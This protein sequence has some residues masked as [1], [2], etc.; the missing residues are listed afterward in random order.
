MR[1]G[2]RN[3]FAGVNFQIE[4]ERA[5]QNA[6]GDQAPDELLAA[7]IRSSIRQGDATSPGGGDELRPGLCGRTSN[8]EAREHGCRKKRAP[9]HDSRPAVSI[10]GDRLRGDPCA[11]CTDPSGRNTG[12]S[13][14]FIPGLSTIFMHSSCLS[15]NIR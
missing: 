7:S 3:S 13:C 2:F 11:Q 8:P 12:G 15:R 14:F 10:E 5:Q 4:R 6:P 9:P 1:S